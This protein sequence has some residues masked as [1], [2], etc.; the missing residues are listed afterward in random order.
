MPKERKTTLA[1]LARNSIMIRR[2]ALKAKKVSA[3]SATSVESETVKVELGEHTEDGNVQ[4]VRRHTHNGY[5]VD[6]VFS[7]A[8]I[9]PE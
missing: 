8:S 4:Q 2:S 1:S 9:S 6:E 7:G 5:V 3:T